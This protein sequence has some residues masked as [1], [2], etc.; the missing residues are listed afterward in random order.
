LFSSSIYSLHNERVKTYSARKKNKCKKTTPESANSIKIKI[1]DE[2]TQRRKNK[3][4]KMKWR[5]NKKKKRKSARI[6]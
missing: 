1:S 4:K 3:A 5:K 6:N 2:K